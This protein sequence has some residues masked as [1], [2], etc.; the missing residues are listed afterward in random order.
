MRTKFSEEEGDPWVVMY[1][2]MG[3]NL[4]ILEA[5]SKKGAVDSRTPAIIQ[6]N[7]FS[8]CLLLNQ[9]IVET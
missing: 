5:T 8:Q 3:N 7:T 6:L 9:K 4:V 2:F 1:E